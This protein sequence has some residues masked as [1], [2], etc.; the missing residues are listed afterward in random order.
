MQASERLATA[1]NAVAR[2]QLASTPT[3]AT[4]NVAA[5]MITAP[6]IATSCEQIRYVK[7]LVC[8]ALELTSSTSVLTQ[9]PLLNSLAPATMNSP[10][11]SSPTPLHGVSRTSTASYLVQLVGIPSQWSTAPLLPQPWVSLPFG[12]LVKLP[13][14]QSTLLQSTSPSTP[15]RTLHPHQPTTRRMRHGAQ[16]TSISR[17]IS[18]LWTTRIS[19]P[20]R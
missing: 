9:A 18:W 15:R 5:A 13:T 14:L 17:A 19:F 20:T 2:S 11:T 10:A 16:R 8:L 6:P 12:T 3:V 7:L 1:T 4:A